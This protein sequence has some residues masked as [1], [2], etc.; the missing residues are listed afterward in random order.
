VVERNKPIG[1]SADVAGIRSFRVRVQS[2]Q[3]S[4]HR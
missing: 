1:T 2:M 3:I 4:K